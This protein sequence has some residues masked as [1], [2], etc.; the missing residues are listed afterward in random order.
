M[1]QYIDDL[2]ESVPVGREPKT[3]LEMQQPSGKARLSKVN[4][5]RHDPIT[6]GAT[7]TPEQ[8]SPSRSSRRVAT[9]SSTRRRSKHTSH[10]PSDPSRPAGLPLHTAP[11]TMTTTTKRSNTSPF[12]TANSLRKSHFKKARHERPCLSP[13]SAKMSG[14]DSL[15]SA[16]QLIDQL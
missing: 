8:G 14:I 13:Q 16:S 9:R 1:F 3:S 2:V 6:V 11:L 4:L 10:L 5:S 12:R 15:L 7:S